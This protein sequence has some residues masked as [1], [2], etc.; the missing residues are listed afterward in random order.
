MSLISLEEAKIYL[1]VD[2]GMDDDLILSLLA[3]AEKLTTDIARMT[4][5]SILAMKAVR[6]ISC[7][8]TASL[9]LLW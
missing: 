5:S 9:R 3:A 1:R 7:M 4:A 2:S 8:P 6:A